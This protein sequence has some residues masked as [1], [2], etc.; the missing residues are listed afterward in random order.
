MAMETERG[1]FRELVEAANGIDLTLLNIL[2]TMQTPPVDPEPCPIP[3]RQ[4]PGE[5]NKNYVIY[6]NEWLDANEP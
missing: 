5:N 3:R 1:L 4:N 6:I 2:E